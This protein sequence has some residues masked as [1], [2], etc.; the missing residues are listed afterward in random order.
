MVDADSLLLQEAIVQSYCLYQVDK[1]GQFRRLIEFEA[2]DDLSG[3]SQ[4]ESVRTFQAMQLWSLGKL[5]R[6][7]PAVD[8]PEP[9]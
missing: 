9:I 7:W 4:A 8:T 1:S 2:E 6:E 3:I 5:V